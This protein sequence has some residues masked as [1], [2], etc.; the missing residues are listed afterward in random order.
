[1][2]VI[3]KSRVHPLAR[4]PWIRGQLLENISK[5]TVLHVDAYI[6]A[7][8]RDPSRPV[9]VI[10]YTEG[11]RREIARDVYLITEGGLVPL[12]EPALGIALQW[13]AGNHAWMARVHRAVLGLVHS[14]GLTLIHNGPISLHCHYCDAR[15]Y[16]PF[17][18]GSLASN[19]YT[20]PKA[21]TKRA[22]TLPDIL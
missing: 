14:G 20:Q 9:L 1:M 7:L 3:E 13:G 6:H 12:W 17:P 11:G 10:E 15:E 2:A 16:D 18:R 22:E 4:R 21:R 8:D 5:R 19:K